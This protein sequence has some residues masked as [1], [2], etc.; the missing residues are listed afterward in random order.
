MI[1]IFMS[2]FFNDICTLILIQNPGFHKLSFPTLVSK[3]LQCDTWYSYTPL[4]YHVLYT[5]PGRGVTAIAYHVEGIYYFR[6]REC[7]RRRLII[8]AALEESRVVALELLCIHV[9]ECFKLL[10]Y[11]V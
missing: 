11:V 4:Q 2:Y 9:L 5:L 10:I 6:Y 8:E 7:S 3:I 1:F